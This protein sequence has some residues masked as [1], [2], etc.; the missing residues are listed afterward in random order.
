MGKIETQT[1]TPNKKTNTTHPKTTTNQ[2]NG[3]KNTTEQTTQNQ[4]DRFNQ[5]Q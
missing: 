4:P 5:A 1:K 2:S 3:N